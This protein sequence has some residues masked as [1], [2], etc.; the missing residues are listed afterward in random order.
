MVYSPPVLVVD[1]S[2]NRSVEVNRCL[3]LRIGNDTCIYNLAGIVYFG[4]AH[5]TAAIIAPNNHF[6]YYDGLLNDGLMADHGLCDII[7][8]IEKVNGRLACAAFYTLEHQ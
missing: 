5:F 8:N 6:W 4:R 2:I 1:V 3:R 7:E